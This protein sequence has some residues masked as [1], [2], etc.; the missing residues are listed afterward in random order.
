MVFWEHIGHLLSQFNFLLYVVLSGF[1][2]PYSSMGV[3]F[4]SH[5]AQCMSFFLLT[6]LFPI[7]L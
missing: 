5:V 6:D 3:P 4:L 7:Q 2:P 1:C